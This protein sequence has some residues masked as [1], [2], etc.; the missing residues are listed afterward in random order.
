MKGNTNN[1]NKL[2]QSTLLGL[3]NEVIA[4]VGNNRRVT[5]AIKHVTRHAIGTFLVLY[6]HIGTQGKPNSIKQQTK[7]NLTHWLKM[8]VSYNYIVHIPQV[9]NLLSSSSSSS[10]SSSPSSS[11]SSFLSFTSGRVYRSSPMGSSR[12]S[13]KGMQ[14]CRQAPSASSS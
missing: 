6:Q 8:T 9:I 1:D 4:L 5:I 2:S 10:S 13:A 11:S 3:I 7:N 12:G 14:R